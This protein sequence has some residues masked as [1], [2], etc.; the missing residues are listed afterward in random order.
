MALGKRAARPVKIVLAFDDDVTDPAIDIENSDFKAYWDSYF[1]I[2]HIKFKDGCEP[3]YFTIRPLTRRQ[4]DAVDALA[5]QRNIAS[6]YIRCGLIRLENYLIYDE[7]NNVTH[8]TSP[9]IE[10]HGQVGEIS[11]E[12]WLDEISFTIDVRDALF[13]AIA[14]IT[15]AKPP[16]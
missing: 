3:T 10:N 8:A 6:W 1:D 9:I 2:K 16:L 15:E 14:H 12:K 11:T 5:G 4:K 13:V 7:S